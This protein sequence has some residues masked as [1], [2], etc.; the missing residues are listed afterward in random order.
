MC[1]PEFKFP[2]DKDLFM[3]FIVVSS[4]ENTTWI[5]TFDQSIFIT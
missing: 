4:D 2:E 1:S 3:L 5:V